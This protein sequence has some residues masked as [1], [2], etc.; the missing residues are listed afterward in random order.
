MAETVDFRSIHIF[1]FSRVSTPY[2]TDTKRFH[3]SFLAH[4]SR[5]TT[6]SPTHVINSIFHYTSRNYTKSVTIFH[7]T[8]QHH[9]NF[10]TLNNQHA[11]R[12]VNGLTLSLPQYQRTISFLCNE[13]FEYI[14]SSIIDLSTYLSVSKSR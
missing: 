3:M 5:H 8:T 1:Q 11:V 2:L 4:V 7:H 9:L 12:T 14:L 6:I 10:N 13:N